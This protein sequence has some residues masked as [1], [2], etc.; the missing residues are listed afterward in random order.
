MPLSNPMMIW[1]WNSNQSVQF[2]RCG[3][4]A[5]A[6][7]VQA[8]MKKRS[9]EVDGEVPSRIFQE[10]VSRGFTKRGEMFSA[11]NMA[12]LARTFLQNVQLV[13]T[14]EMSEAE[15]R[16]MIVTNS[17]KGNYFLVP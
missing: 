9:G 11:D 10:A 1:I 3:L 5:L 2:V 8:E 14:M 16:S 15:I 6:M 12:S 13:N 4:A 7:A 17:L